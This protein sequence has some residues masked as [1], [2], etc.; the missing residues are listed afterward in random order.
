MYEI[1]LFLYDCDQQGATIFDYLSLKGCT[2]FGRF[3]H[4]SSG[5]HNCKLSF[6]YCQPVLLQAGI[7]DEMELLL[8]AYCPFV[9]ICTYLWLNFCI[10]FFARLQDCEK[11]L[12]VSSFLSIRPSGRMQQ[13]GFH[14][15]DFH[16]VW[17]LRA[18]QMSVG[19]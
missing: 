5:A 1:M 3:L 2:C 11:R 6:K 13:L 12:L 19:K 18:L 4:P 14:W 7:V 16:E 10:F 17:Y 8:V 15:T 9:S